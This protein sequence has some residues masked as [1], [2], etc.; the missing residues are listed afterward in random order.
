MATAREDARRTGMTRPFRV[1]HSC[2]SAR[3][4]TATDRPHAVNYQMQI[5]DKIFLAWLGLTTF[6]TF[7]LFGYDKFMAGRAGRRVSE[8]HL[9]LFAALGGGLGGLLGMFVF[10][11]KTAKRSFQLKYAAGFLVWGGLLYPRFA[12]R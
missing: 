4:G 5:V 11:H 12:Y 6:L 9:V 1:D 3:L 8:F 10:R 7:G 2:S